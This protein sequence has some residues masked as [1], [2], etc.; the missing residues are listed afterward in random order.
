MTRL[1]SAAHGTL[2]IPGLTQ[3]IGPKGGLGEHGDSISSHLIL[4]KGLHEDE[5]S[6]S[7]ILYFDLTIILCL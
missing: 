7:F 5:A 6:V 4:M 1:R 2:N 3:G